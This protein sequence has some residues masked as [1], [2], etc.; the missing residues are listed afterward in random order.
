MDIYH[1][2]KRLGCGAGQ[3][4]VYNELSCIAELLLESK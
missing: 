3:A 2:E 4:N 1:G